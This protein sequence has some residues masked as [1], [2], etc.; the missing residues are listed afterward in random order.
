MNTISSTRLLHRRAFTLIEL[1]VVIAIIAI[2]A[3]LLLPALSRAKFKARDIQCLSNEKQICLSVIM[4]IS[5]N[6]NGGMMPY[7]NIHV[8]VDQLQVGYAAI[9]KVRYCPA[10]SEKIP[11]GGATASSPSSFDPGAFGTADYPW[12]WINWS[13]GTYDAQGSYGFNM[14]CYTEMEQYPGTGIPA[15]D[16]AT[17]AFQKE[18]A[19]ISAART[20]LFTDNVWVDGAVRVEHTLGTDLYNGRW[21]SGSHWPGWNGHY[22]ARGT[23]R[24]RCSTQGCRGQRVTR[25]LQ[26]GHTG[27]ACGVRQI[28][29]SYGLLLE[30][31]LAAL[32][33]EQVVG[34]GEARLGSATYGKQP[35]NILSSISSTGLPNRRAFTLIELLVVIAIIAILAAMLLPA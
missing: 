14:W 32:I 5:D 18:A 33:S 23:E 26:C 15:A 7:Q 1:L 9:K 35:S 2:L 17:Y 3:A 29:Q 25:T 4:Y 31:T 11:W 16:C 24:Q 13:S 27:W 10:A 22:A 34:T 21:D 20:P 19:V 28:E 30:Q 8:W 6:N 12:C